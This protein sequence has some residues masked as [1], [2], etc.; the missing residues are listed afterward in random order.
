MYVHNNNILRFIKYTG[1]IIIIFFLCPLFMGTYCKTFTYYGNEFTAFFPDLFE[2]SICY[3]WSGKLHLTHR[4][5]KDSELTTKR[6]KYFIVVMKFH[7][8]HQY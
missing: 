5:Q 1:K 7:F 3:V 8:I 2:S 4:Y 6:K